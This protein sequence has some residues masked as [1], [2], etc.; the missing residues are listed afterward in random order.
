M[1]SARRDE[2]RT[3]LRLFGTAFATIALP[4][5]VTAILAQPAASRRMQKL[6]MASPDRAPSEPKLVSSALSAG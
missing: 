4:G 5:K 2:T 6:S 3:L 1:A